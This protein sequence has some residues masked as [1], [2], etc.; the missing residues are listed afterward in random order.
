MDAESDY[1]TTAS[2]EAGGGSEGG[3]SVV[4]RK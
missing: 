1:V 2:K 3:E 4:V